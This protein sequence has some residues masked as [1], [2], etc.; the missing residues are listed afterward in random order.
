LWTSNGN[1]IGGGAKVGFSSSGQRPLLAF[2]P[3]VEFFH[4]LKRNHQK[5]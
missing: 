2:N 3:T 1:S 4:K 5:V